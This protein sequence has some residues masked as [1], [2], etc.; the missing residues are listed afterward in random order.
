MFFVFVILIFPE[1]IFMARCNISWYLVR[2]KD[3]MR[4][5]SLFLIPC[6]GGGSALRDGSCINMVLFVG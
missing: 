1:H 2:E 3:G 4:G 5:F 6:A